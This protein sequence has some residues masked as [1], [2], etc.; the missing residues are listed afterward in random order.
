MQP[1]IPILLID[2]ARLTRDSLSSLLQDK[3]PDFLVDV[4]PDCN[5]AAAWPQI[6]ALLLFNAKD[7]D[8]ADIPLR[9]GSAQLAGLWPGTPRLMISER[10]DHRLMAL[11]AV[12][13][14][15]RGFFPASLKVEMLVAAIRLVLSGG[16]FIPP[17]VVEQCAALLASVPAPAN[18][19][20]LPGFSNR[21]S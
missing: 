7:A 5:A 2:A 17:A 11:E 18:G 15:W 14:G 6:P 20:G 8:L 13:S 10:R 3:A 4:I 19:R 21:G 12:Q 1:R 16:I 9:E